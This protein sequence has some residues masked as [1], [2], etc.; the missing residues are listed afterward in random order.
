MQALPNLVK[1]YLSPTRF[2]A[3]RSRFFDLE[4]HQAI[5][6][7]LW[8][9][10][11]LEHMGMNVLARRVGAQR[12]G[13]DREV[14]SETRVSVAVAALESGVA[15][16]TLRTSYKTICLREQTGLDLAHQKVNVRWDHFDVV[17]VDDVASQRVE[18]T[19]LAAAFLFCHGL[20]FFP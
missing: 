13:T 8:T 3:C 4:L 5:L 16:R 9:L 17:G 10:A 2:E 18:V 12:L 1:E 6:G 19:F 20:L 11:A 14:F 15:H 7:G